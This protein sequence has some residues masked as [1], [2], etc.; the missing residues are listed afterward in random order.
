MTIVSCL[1]FVCRCRLSYGGHTTPCAIAC[2]YICAHVKNPVVHLRV[3]WIMETPKHSARTVGWVARFCLS[4]LS[5]GRATRN[6]HGKTSHWD[7]AVVNKSEIKSK[8]KY[9]LLPY[10]P[11]LCSYMMSHRIPDT[12][13]QRSNAHGRD[14]ATFKRRC[15]NINHETTQ[16]PSESQFLF[17]IKKK[18]KTKKRRRM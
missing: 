9:V 6:S 7:Y 15:I 17:L 1:S 18:K 12:K 14:F 5:P 3:R 16:S 8:S 10:L 13:W 4:W 11:S 2:I